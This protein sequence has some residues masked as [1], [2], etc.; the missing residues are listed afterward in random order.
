MAW[1]LFIISSQLLPMVPSAIDLP[2]GIFTLEPTN[3]DRRQL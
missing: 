3:D 2:M 1:S